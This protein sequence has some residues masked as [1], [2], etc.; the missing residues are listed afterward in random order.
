MT[1]PP[2]DLEGKTVRKCRACGGTGIFRGSRPIPCYSCNGSGYVVVGTPAALC[3]H[4]YGYGMMCGHRCSHCRGTGYA[5]LYYGDL[6][7]NKDG[8]EIENLI[9]G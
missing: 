8:E 2:L 9:G 1:R 4:C 3:E 5:A 7:V 6:A